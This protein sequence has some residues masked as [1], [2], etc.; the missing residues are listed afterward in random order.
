MISSL[1]VYF[2]AICIWI[3]TLEQTVCLCA[4]ICLL[5]SLH[6]YFIL[7]LILQV[8]FNTGKSKAD[9]YLLK[10]QITT[11]NLINEINN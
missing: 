3:S 11:N 7:Y 8:I 1:Q 9:V 6:T 2:A 10:Y 4:T 5:Y